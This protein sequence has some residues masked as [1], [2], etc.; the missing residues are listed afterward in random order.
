MELLEAEMWDI[1][2]T[3]FLSGDDSDLVKSRLGDRGDIC[4]YKT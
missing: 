2:S 1:S 4:E 3:P